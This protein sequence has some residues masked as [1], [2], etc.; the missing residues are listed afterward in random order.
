LLRR[1]YGKH[2]LMGLFARCLNLF[3]L[4]IFRQ[5]AVLPDGRSLF[6]HGSAN[7]LELLFLRIRQ[8]ELLG[9]HRHMLLA[10]GH[11]SA[12]LTTIGLGAARGLALIAA[13]ALLL[14]LGCQGQKH[15][16]YKCCKQNT[17]REFWHDLSFA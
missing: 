1:Q 6:P 10:A 5:R 14:G 8:A 16:R 7:L 17:M 3:F 13:L 12:S 15:D 2:L 4:L 11:A 9:D